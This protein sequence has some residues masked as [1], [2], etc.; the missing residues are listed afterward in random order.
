MQP[1][2]FVEVDLDAIAANIRL[3]LQRSE[4]NV[5]AVVKADAYGHGLIPISE[6]AIEA[7]ATWLGVALLEEALAL[8]ASGITVPIIAWLTPPGEDLE[9]ALKANIDLSISSLALLDEILKVSQRVG[10]RPRIHIEID[11]G[12]R[13]GG[14]LDEWNDFLGR[15]GSEKD[16]MIF[17]GA[18]THF[19][20]ADEPDSSFTD[21]QI[22]EFEFRINQLHEAGIDPEF[23]HLSNSAAALTKNN[24]ARSF[25]RL[26]ISMYGLT[27]DL[28]TLGSG[29]DFG[30]TPAMSLHAKLALVK[31]A[32]IGSAVGYG[33]TS[34]LEEETQLGVVVL[35][36]ADGIPRN[37]GKGAGVSINGERFPLVGRVSMD[38]FVVDL[39][40]NSQAKAGEYV[41][42]FGDNGYS[43]DEW[44]QASSTINYEIVTRIATRVPRIYRSS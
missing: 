35:G 5:L 28:A 26:G 20:R 32:P 30:L 41:T 18:W 12:M 10:I 11:T 39:G 34:V 19:A 8:R 13:R 14:F 24:R 25:V 44:A 9:L 31:R 43:I 1:R 15:V 37:A 27:P 42:V 2:A 33:G 21:Q 4:T 6:R 7:G 40:A 29:S 22:A 3:V 16:R 23:L 36:Y 38:Q 17:V